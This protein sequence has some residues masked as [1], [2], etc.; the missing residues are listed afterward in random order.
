MSL[1]YKKILLF[2]FPPSEDEQI[3]ASVLPKDFVDSMKIQNT[4]GVYSLLPYNNTRVRSAVH[5]LKFHNHA[6][7]KTL[8]SE[9]LAAYLAKNI[10][11]EYIIIPIPLS[12]T[13]KRQRGYNQV[14]EIIKGALRSLPMATLEEHILV[15]THNTTPQTSLPRTER[16]RNVRDAFSIKNQR[17]A[18]EKLTGRHLV[19]IDDVMTTGATLREARIVLKYYCPEK[20]TC[21]ALAH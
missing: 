13:R 5:L 16:L 11:E 6:Q 2:L 15:R 4:D 9:V 3:I 20:I 21:V 8:L 18:T 12:K 1:N 14:T 17:T 19:L 10:L 7:A